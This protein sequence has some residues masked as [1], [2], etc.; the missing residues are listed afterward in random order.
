M[1]T[2]VYAFFFVALGVIEYFLLFQKARSI[3]YFVPFN[4]YNNYFLS[5]F[6]VYALV[7]GML[8]WGLFIKI[9]R[10]TFRTFL[11]IVF[12]IVFYFLFVAIN[13]YKING[14]AP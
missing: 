12:Y 1:A 13:T 11:I 9:K 5:T 3:N 14:Y 8:Y 10:V 4:S 7:A 6:A 2:L